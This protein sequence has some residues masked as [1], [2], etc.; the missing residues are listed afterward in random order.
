MIDFKPLDLSDRNLFLKYLGHYPFYSYEYSFLSLYFWKDYCNVHYGLYKDVL[1]IKKSEEHKGSYFIQPLGCPDHLLS[2]L[3]EV[4]INIKQQDASF[5]DLFREIE[6]PFLLRI[7]DLYEVD[8]CSQEE[9]NNFDYLYETQ[10]LINLPGDKLRKKKNHYNQFINSY[11]YS[12]KDISEKDVQIDCL[13]LATS[14]L[15]SQKTKYNEIIFELEGIRNIFNNIE[16]LN[17]LGMAIYVNNSLAGFTIGEKVNEKMAIVHVEKG[18]INYKGIYAFL[19]KVFAEKYLQDT[20]Y[21]NREEDLGISG[22][23]KA[24]LAYEPSML[25]KKHIV[26]FRK[27]V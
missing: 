7:K 20:Y 5:K 18:N 25:V 2:E 19:N 11:H 10:K 12:I 27:K 3:L 23:R 24:K 13:D 17:V 26:N 15:E 21:I 22:L 1:I 14:W 9:E 6:E 16:Y 8:I 4:L